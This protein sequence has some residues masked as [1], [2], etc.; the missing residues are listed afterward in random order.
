[1]VG[2]TPSALHGEQHQTG[3]PLLVDVNPVDGDAFANKLFANEIAH[4]LGADA[5]DQRRL[6]PEPRRSDRNV[7]RAAAYRFGET[8]DVL[9]SAADLLA[10]EI[11]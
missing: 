8:S 5:R 7:G 9:E 2:E 3:Q 6:E 1:M 11:D 4:L 10:I